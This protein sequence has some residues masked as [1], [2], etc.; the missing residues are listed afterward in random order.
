MIKL[1]HS[2]IFELYIYFT[3]V[4]N[5]ERCEEFDIIEKQEQ[6]RG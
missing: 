2:G 5:H 1:N 4:G 3:L 6:K